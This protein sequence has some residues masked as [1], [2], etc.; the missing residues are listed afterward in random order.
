MGFFGKIGIDWHL[1][2]AQVVNFGLLV[3]LFRRFVY[4]PLL[5][6]MSSSDLEE[7][8][9]GMAS[10]KQEREK[11]GNERDHILTEAKSRSAEMV[12]EAEV[13]AGRIKD[14]VKAEAAQERRKFMK[15]LESQAAAQKDALGESLSQATRQELLTRLGDRFDRIMSSSPKAASELQASYGRELMEDIDKVSRSDFDPKDRHLRVLYAVGTRNRDGAD[16]ARQLAEGLS[17]KMVDSDI[18]PNLKQDKSLL[19]GYRLEASGLMLERSLSQDISH[20]VEI[21]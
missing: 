10:I 16:L 7:A 21:Q 12:E 17:G 6:G 2:V 9:R 19:A 20:A 3:W 18:E 13:I 5:Q 4:R 1:L 15:H 11:A 8:E 14:R